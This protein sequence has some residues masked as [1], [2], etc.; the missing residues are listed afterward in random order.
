MDPSRTPDLSILS[1]LSKSP[2]TSSS[3][4]PDVSRLS[5]LSR[6]TNDSDAEKLARLGQR[7][8]PNTQPKSTPGALSRSPFTRDDD[9]TRMYINYTISED[10]SGSVDEVMAQRLKAL[11]R[12]DE[13]PEQPTWSQCRWE[14]CKDSWHVDGK[15]L[16]QHF[17]RT[18]IL[19]LEAFEEPH[20]FRCPWEEPHKFRCPWEG[21]QLIFTFSSSLRT[22]IFHHISSKV[23]SRPGYECNDCHDKF[24]NTKERQQHYA[25]AHKFPKFPT[26]SSG[27][28]SNT[29]TTVRKGLRVLVAEDNSVSQEVMRRLLRLED[30]DGA[31]VM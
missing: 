25:R 19:T 18:H 13:A 20:K 2:F 7:Q 8:R 15:S 17:Y 14:G 9:D 1:R 10:R 22:H 26:E 24:A 4:A 27:F 31:S 12:R 29:M 21:C 30:I 23:Y 6:S 11:S 28:G 16:F 5:Q 3:D